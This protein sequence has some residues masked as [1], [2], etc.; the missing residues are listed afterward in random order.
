MTLLGPNVPPPACSRC[1][2]DAAGQCECT[3]CDVCDQALPRDLIGGDENMSCCYVCQLEHAVDNG[4]WVVAA[5]HLEAL[6]SW[7]PRN[8]Q[9]PAWARKR[10][11]VVLA[12]Y[13]ERIASSRGA[14]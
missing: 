12:R 3:S 9:L 10:I 7:V 6:R 13:G 4:V 5:G 1:G 11:A 2:A 14:A 8:Y